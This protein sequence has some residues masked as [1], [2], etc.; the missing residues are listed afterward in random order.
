MKVTPGALRW[1]T[2]TAAR[3]R[4]SKLQGNS[5]RLGLEAVENLR[6]EKPESL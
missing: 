4:N 5:E 2:V 1:S 3:R 6:G